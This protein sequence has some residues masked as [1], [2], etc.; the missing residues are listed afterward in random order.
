MAS[1]TRMLQLVKDLD[2]K[3]TR[4]SLREDPKLVDFRDERGRNWLHLACMVNVKK[5][6]LKSSDQLKTVRVL[7]DVGFNVDDA[8]F[9]EGCGWKATPVWHAVARAKSHELVKFL[10]D[11]GADPNHSLFAAP[12]RKMMD[13]LVRHGA[14]VD[15]P[16]FEHGTPFLGA[17]KFSWFEKAEELL[18]LG[19][20]VNTVDEQG[21]TALHLMLKK[22]SDK[23]H[24]R[25]LMKYKP[26]S[27]IEDAKGRTAFEIMSRKRDPEFRKWA[28]QL[29]KKS[30]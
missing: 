18:K 6:K 14:I 20:D 24:F 4:D 3:A 28:E 5:R 17:V 22:D 8:A 29:S 21:R 25:M 15:D 26:R 11:R 13:L 23:K 1:K 12:D 16:G 7:L 10:L 2:W 9:T 27:D 19:A 30:G